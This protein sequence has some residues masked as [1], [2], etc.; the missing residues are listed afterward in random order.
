M[1]LLLILTVLSL[2]FYTLFLPVQQY[3][4]LQR[5]HTALV[6]GHLEA[7]MAHLAEARKEAPQLY[8]ERASALCGAITLAQ[9]RR[10]LDS[11]TPDF[12]GAVGR[13]RAMETRCGA[14]G[15]EDDAAHLLDTTAFRHLEH[16]TTRCRQRDYAGA[17]AAFQQIAL[18]P[19]P[20][21]GLT[22][23]Q[24]EAAWCQLAHATTLA[25]Q[26]RFEAAF[27]LLHRLL[28][29]APVFMREAAL[30]QVPMVVQEELDYWQA[31]MQFVQLFKQFTQRQRTFGDYPDTADF[32]TQVGRQL[33]LQVFG[34]D[35]GQQCRMTLPPPRRTAGKRG[36]PMP[37][38][39][40][41]GAITVLP[42]S[43]ATLPADAGTANLVLQ[44]DTP[45]PLRIL[46]RG[47]EQRD[48]VL[49]SRAT[50][51]LTLEPA[52][53]LVGIYAPGNCRVKSER[54]A[55]TVREKAPYSVRFYERQT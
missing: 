40:L 11:A 50:Q 52:E 43:M 21:R 22:Q 25:R 49:G 33:E 5:A 20:E 32:F 27:E 55:W 44:N 48:V 28:T 24:D 31:R 34:V 1:K 9:A 36:K 13:L 18:L 38:G 8:A 3:M 29:A 39:P 19:Y 54:T 30:K 23:A 26:Q 41:P 2:V 42:A 45:H 53:Y 6:A 47:Q 37:Q 17:Q 14:S 51:A 7:A 16:A 35:F 15:R 10:L 4:A 12:G 46:L